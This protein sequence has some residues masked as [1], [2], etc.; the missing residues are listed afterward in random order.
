M[1]FE[2]TR[3]GIV[4]SAAGE[5]RESLRVSGNWEAGSIYKMNNLK[6]MCSTKAKIK[7]MIKEKNKKKD[8]FKMS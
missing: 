7:Y 8:I 1:R 5:R 3:Q 4:Q 6:K 2:T